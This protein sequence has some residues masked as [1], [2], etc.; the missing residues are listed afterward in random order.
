[1]SKVAIQKPFDIQK[2]LN[3]YVKVFQFF[4]KNT[5]FQNIL[6]E[7]FRCYN[8]PPNQTTQAALCIHSLKSFLTSNTITI[9]SIPVIEIPILDSDIKRHNPTL[10]ISGEIEGDKKTLRRFSFAICI[11]FTS[12]KCEDGSV[13]SKDTLKS[14]SC[15][16]KNH[17]GKKRVIRRFHF[18]YQ[19]YDHK[20]PL[21]THFQFGGIFPGGVY[22][23]ELHYCLEPFLE[24]PR[25]PCDPWDYV[26]LLNCLITQFD[27]PLN[28]WKKETYWNGLVR[29]NDENI[30]NLT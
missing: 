30:E 28:Q 21:V 29:A 2:W 27:T 25:I 7:G 23:H 17:S 11:T 19:P 26:K 9:L 3:N 1:V 16:I 6:S 24:K 8:I 15:C 13:V 12:P 18:D 14:D 5:H 20:E 4:E 22:S 10:L